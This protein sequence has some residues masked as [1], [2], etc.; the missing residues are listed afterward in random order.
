MRTVN[1]HTLLGEPDQDLTGIESQIL[2]VALGLERRHIARFAVAMGCYGGRPVTV[3]KVTE[4]EKSQGRGYP[5]DLR[6]ALENIES[7]VDA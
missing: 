3:E 5:A 6:E 7:A 4:W 1:R 2:R